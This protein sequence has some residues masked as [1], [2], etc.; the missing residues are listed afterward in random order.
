MRTRRPLEPLAR[1]V[2]A[3][4]VAIAAT[5]ALAQSPAPPNAADLY[6]QAAE[7][8]TTH[9]QG[10]GATLTN[11]EIE[12]LANGVDGTLTPIQQSAYAKAKPYIDLVRA[13]GRESA[14]DF[15]LDYSQG[16]D[17][18]LPHLS[19]MRNATR[20][21]RFDAQ[22]RMLDGDA[23]GAA[24]N[25]ECMIGAGRHA[26]GDGILISSLV[27]AAILSMQDGVLDEALGRGA[28]DADRAAALAKDLDA[29]RGNDPLGL[30]DALRNEGVLASKSI[31]G[32]LDGPGGME[33]LK[34]M[35]AGISG[36]DDERFADL[37]PDAVREQ[38]SRYT[39]LTEELAT[40]A[41]NPDR[42]KAAKAV[43]DIQARIEAGEG[44][45]VALLLLP[46]VDRAMSVNWRIV[47]MVAARLAALEEIRDGKRAP[48]AFAN[49]AYAYLHLAALID[50]LPEEA[51]RDIEAARVAG[52]ALE[53]EAL[54]RTRRLV[55]PLREA[56]QREFRAAAKCGR[57]DFSIRDPQRLALAPQ[58]LGP[59]RGA[60]RVA[61]AD[62]LLGP[63]PQGSDGRVRG[64]DIKPA[65]L[66]ESIGWG[67]TLARHLS[68][69]HAICNSLI[70][71]SALADVNAALSEAMRRAP[72]APD[73]LTAL[74]D[75]LDR[76]EGVDPVGFRLASASDRDRIQKAFVGN[77][78]NDLLTR[79]LARRD[80]AELA[81][82]LLAFQLH[83]L[84]LSLP[85]A[86]SYPLS[87]TQ[88]AMPLNGLGDLISADAIEPSRQAA[89]TCDETRAGI[90]PQQADQAAWRRVIGDLIATPRPCDT[91]AV[92]TKGVAAL[93]ALRDATRVSA[94]KP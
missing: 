59:L 50:G 22:A 63:S 20:L 24:E 92:E 54:E 42:E 8:W 86:P 81:S 26:R 14:V 93:A 13:A 64:S 23:A 36:A 27:S 2:L 46:S 5:G 43:A 28:I 57:C 89:R 71:A 17:L 16:F 3:T 76:F 79:E 41:T 37:T 91:T 18:T 87:N 61:L 58:Y 70:A 72:L 84:D 33:A 94:P 73:A 62:A 38:V 30:G 15:K 39:A 67:L 51:Q 88:L 55:S 77:R 80:V 10:D 47:D 68:G 25:L 1:T 60:L 56:L 4:I 44:G 12:A 19:P 31:L 9:T 7:W 69:D 66:V 75:R 82:V 78:T 52:A 48:E 35:V 11:E 74:R 21:L 90:D 65:E 49:A 40:A 34:T 32:K 6:R 85:L 29:F 53:A 45:V 83:T